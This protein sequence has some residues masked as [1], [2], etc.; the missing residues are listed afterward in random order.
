MMEWLHKI[1]TSLVFFIKNSLDAFEVCRDFEIPCND[2]FTFFNVMVCFKKTGIK[3]FA[4]ALNS[5]INLV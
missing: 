5:L 3:S 2:D 1:T 4:K